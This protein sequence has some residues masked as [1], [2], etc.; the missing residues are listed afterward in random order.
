MAAAAGQDRPSYL[1]SLKPLSTRR[2]GKSVAARKRREHGDHDLPRAAAAAAT[3]TR[4]HPS[5][6]AQQLGFD[7]RSAR[8]AA[9]P[10]P[11]CSAALRKPPPGSAAIYSGPA[12]AASTQQGGAGGG[13]RA[14]G[15]GPVGGARG[16][17]DGELLLAVVVPQLN[18]PRDVAEPSQHQ[19]PPVRRP[20]HRVPRA[21]PEVEHRLALPPPPPPPHPPSR[22]LRGELG[23]GIGRGEGATGH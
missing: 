16:L 9:K 17:D 14:G 23:G 18:V 2:R 15:G 7:S 19:E 10:S 8:R 13:G 22:Q 1:K 20:R 12:P 6:P 3:R 5:A 4:P 21:R 11:P